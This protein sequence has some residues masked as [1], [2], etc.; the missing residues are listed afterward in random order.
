M[1]G[2]TRLTVHA[3]NKD[4]QHDKHKVSNTKINRKQSPDMGIE[5]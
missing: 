1:K 5:R 4:E 3:L 2:A